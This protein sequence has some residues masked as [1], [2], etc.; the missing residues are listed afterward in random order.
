MRIART[1]RWKPETDKAIDRIAKETGLSKTA[2]LELFIRTFGQ[3]F[4]DRQQPKKK[5]KK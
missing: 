2:A 3:Q 4:I 5:V 1:Y